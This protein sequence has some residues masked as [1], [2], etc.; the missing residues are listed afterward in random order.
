[1]GEPTLLRNLG[2]GFSNNWVSGIW[3]E[4]HTQA[5]VRFVSRNGANLFVGTVEFAK[6]LPDTWFGVK[7]EFDTAEARCF[8]DDG[9]GFVL[10]ETISQHLPTTAVLTA[11]YASNFNAGVED[12]GGS[13]LPSIDFDLCDW[14]CLGLLPIT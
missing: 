1:M 9:G 4:R 5:D 10:K 2:G 3:L 7:I 14:K 11:A 6:P 12:G 13:G 8:F